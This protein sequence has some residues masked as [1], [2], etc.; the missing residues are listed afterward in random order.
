VFL[1]GPNDGAWISK[2]SRF[3]GMEFPDVHG[4]CDYAGPTSRS[5]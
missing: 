4:V 1:L 3:S 5:H 2:V